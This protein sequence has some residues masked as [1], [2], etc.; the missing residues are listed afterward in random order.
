MYVSEGVIPLHPPFLHKMAFLLTYFN[1]VA[2]IIAIGTT[3]KKRTNLHCQP[4]LK[5]NHLFFKQTPVIPASPISL[6]LFLFLF[7]YIVLTPKVWI[8]RQ[9]KSKKFVWLAIL[10]TKK[11]NRLDFALDTRNKSLLAKQIVSQNCCYVKIV[12]HYMI[13]FSRL[14]INS[15]KCAAILKIP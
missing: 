5:S 15:Y 3:K 12:I 2:T 13:T 9:L 1:L 4:K 14:T 8:T 6:F 10:C 11:N 7:S